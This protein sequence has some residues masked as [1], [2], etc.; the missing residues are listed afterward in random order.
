M[1]DF[2]VLY[3][4]NLSQRKNWKLLP[5]ILS[6]GLYINHL[7]HSCSTTPLMDSLFWHQVAFHASEYFCTWSNY[8][9]WTILLASSSIISLKARARSEGGTSNWRELEVLEPSCLLSSHLLFQQPAASYPYLVYFISAKLRKETGLTQRLKI[10]QLKMLQRT[11]D[12]LNR[13]V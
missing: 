13:K 1:V 9:I 7:A 8:F 4:N 12:G 5:Y 11:K 6:L 2:C 3:W 10:A